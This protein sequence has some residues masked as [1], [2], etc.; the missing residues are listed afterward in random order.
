MTNGAGGSQQNCFWEKL[1]FSRM[2]RKLQ[3]MSIHILR[4]L[5]SESLIWDRRRGRDRGVAGKKNAGSEEGRNN[6]GKNRKQQRTV[7]TFP[8]TSVCPATCPVATVTWSGCKATLK[9]KHS[10]NVIKFIT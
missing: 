5:L 2:L 6:L 10:N 3:Y 9:S 7:V 4:Y 1:E 8:S